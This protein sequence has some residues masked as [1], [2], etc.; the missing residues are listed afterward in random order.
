MGKTAKFELHPEMP[1]GPLNRVADN[2]LA[3]KLLGWE[4]KTMFID[5]LHRTIDWYVKDRKQSEVSAQLQSVLT[6]R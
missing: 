5:G 2:A 3:K 1:T 6:E 4:P